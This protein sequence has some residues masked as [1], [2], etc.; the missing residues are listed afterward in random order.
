MRLL[1]LML[2]S[3]LSLASSSAFAA[4]YQRTDGTVVDPILVR[5]TAD[6]HAYVGADLGPS[7]VAIGADLSFAHLESAD[8]SG[9]NLSGAN[10]TNVKGESIVRE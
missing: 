1:A 6:V 10:L 7:V 5:R 2:I 4:S 3:A 9:A 8:L